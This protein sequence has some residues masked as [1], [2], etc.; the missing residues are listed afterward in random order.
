M[1]RPAQGGQELH[2]GLAV[3][4]LTLVVVSGSNAPAISARLLRR[5]DARRL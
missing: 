5:E 3:S 1:V 4:S 2:P